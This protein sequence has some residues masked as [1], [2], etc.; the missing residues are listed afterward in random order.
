MSKLRLAIE[1]RPIS[2]WGVTLANL[3]P[4]EEWDKLRTQCY[5]EADYSCEVCGADGVKLNAHEVWTFDDRQLIQRLVAL[6]CCC[7]L[8]HAVHHFG[9][10]TQV[11]SKSY[12]R[13]LIKHW[14]EVNNL[15]E[16]D[17]QS[18][19]ADIKLLN[20]KRADKFYIVKVGRKILA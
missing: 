4:R 5:R 11:Y 3:L 13:Q 18:H 7:E 1:P 10:S 15:T 12:Q 19:L 17:F 6:E 20:R 8:C 9:R 16:K 14:C 2:T